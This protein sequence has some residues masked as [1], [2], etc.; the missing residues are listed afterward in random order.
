MR[1]RTFIAATGAGTGCNLFLRC[2]A[3]KKAQNAETIFP[4]IAGE[5]AQISPHDLAVLV[6]MCAHIFPGDERCPDAAQLGIENFLRTQ[7]VTSH[8]SK[9]TAKL[10]E[11][12]TLIQKRAVETAGREYADCTSMQQKAILDECA[13]GVL[14]QS[15]RV[16]FNE[17]VD[18]TLEGCFSDPL[19]GANA[20]KAG[21]EIMSRSLEYK[22]FGYG[23]CN[24]ES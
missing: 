3:G 4:R 5:T 12:M 2:A 11:F 21:W 1:R 15:A 20:D 6:A 16:V 7:L 8:Y 18:I 22:W 17:L 14:S 19:H 9:L 13:N 10:P 23:G 24:E